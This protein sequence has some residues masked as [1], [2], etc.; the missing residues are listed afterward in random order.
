MSDRIYSYL[1]Y[2]TLNFKIFTKTR[3]LALKFTFFKVYVQQGWLK[4][5][6]FQKPPPLESKILENPY[7]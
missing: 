6:V 2:A 5:G 3:F 7:S 4:G 1:K